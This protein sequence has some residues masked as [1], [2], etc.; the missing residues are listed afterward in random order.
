MKYFRDLIAVLTILALTVQISVAQNKSSS[1]APVIKHEPVVT[2]VRDQPISVRAVVTSSSSD[3]KSVTLFFTTSKDAAPFKIA[4]QSSGAE[5][6]FGSIPSSFLKGVKELSYYIEALDEQSVA[7]ETR[8]YTVKLQAPNS[9]STATAQPSVAPKSQTEASRDSWSWKGPAIIAGGTAAIVGGAILLANNG[10]DS[11]SS[12]TNTSSGS[13]TTTNSTD[14][15]YTGTATK[16]LLMSGASSPTGSSYAVIITISSAGTVSSDTLQP[17]AH[18]EAQLSGSDFQ[19]TSQISE[20]NLSGQIAFFGNV[21]NNRITG[22]IS[23]SVTTTSGTNG[24][25]SGIFSASK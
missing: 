25:Y 12:S 13:T 5:T 19:L 9:A 11:T 16:Y 23:G 20:T 8:W 4:M 14:G 3:L 24:I 18:M 15:T 10:S 17:G 21:A 7:S 2:A 6:Y 1:K 22:T